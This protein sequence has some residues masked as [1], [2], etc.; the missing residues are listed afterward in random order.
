MLYQ[1]NPKSIKEWTEVFYNNSVQKKKDGTGKRV[2]EKY[3][4]L[5]GDEL[6]RLLNEKIFPLIMQAKEE[7]TIEDCR[8]FIKD[9]V[10]RRSYE[11]FIAEKDVVSQVE[12]E[13]DGDI[14]FEKD[15]EMESINIDAFGKSLKYNKI[16]GLSIKPISFKKQDGFSKDESLKKSWEKWERDNN[17]K[18]F[19]VYYT[20]KK[21]G[22]K[23]IIKD[24]E[25]LITQILDF[26]S[27]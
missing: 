5:V 16:I 18:I 12:I 6:F 7:L 2:D 19:I 9:V 11:G 13:F 23:K 27:T 25:E 20:E 15:A 22:Q 21:E 17:S 3:L 1:Y 24:K 10:I 8:D 26:L 14:V 4:D